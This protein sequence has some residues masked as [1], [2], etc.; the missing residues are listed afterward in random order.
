MPSPFPF[1]EPDDS[2]NITSDQADQDG[3]RAND[4]LLQNSAR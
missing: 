2:T 4:E 1:V 3:S